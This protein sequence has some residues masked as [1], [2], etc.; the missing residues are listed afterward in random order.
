MESAA[1]FGDL[2]RICGSKTNVL[3]GLNIFEKEGNMRQIYKKISECLPIQVSTPRPRS[4]LLT[5]IILTE[6]F[7]IS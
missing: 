2:C 5:Q 7:Y 3:M 6:T 4:R 1:E